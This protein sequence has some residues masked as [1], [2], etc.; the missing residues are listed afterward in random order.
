MI[1]DI[2]S[3]LSERV[4][5]RQGDITLSM[6]DQ[7]GHWKGHVAVDTLVGEIVSIRKILVFKGSFKMT[8]QP[9]AIAVAVSGIWGNPGEEQAA[10][11]GEG[12]STHRGELLGAQAQA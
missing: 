10:N 1:P 3:M 4:Q 11:R 5:I 9:D 8:L 6:Q 7:A 2:Q 12:F